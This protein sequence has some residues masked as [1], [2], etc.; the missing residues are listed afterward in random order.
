MR[1]PAPQ[2]GSTKGWLLPGLAGFATLTIVACFDRKIAMALAI[3]FI[4]FAAIS[5]LAAL[6]RK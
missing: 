1:G 3:C 6:L 4:S 2:N 5:M